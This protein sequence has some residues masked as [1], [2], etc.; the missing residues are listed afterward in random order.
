[1]SKKK[2]REENA[3]KKKQG[4]EPPSNKSPVQDRF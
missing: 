3:V 4:P 2:E 1:M